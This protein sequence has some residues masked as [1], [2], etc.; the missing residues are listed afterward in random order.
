M[1]DSFTDIKTMINAHLYT[2]TVQTVDYN[3]NKSNGVS[4]RLDGA[5]VLP[6]PEPEQKPEPNPDFSAYKNQTKWFYGI[7]GPMPDDEVWVKPGPNRA[8]E[9]VWK[10]EYGWYDVNKTHLVDKE[11][12]NTIIANDNELCWAATSSNILHWWLRMNEKYVK[13]YDE[14]NPE[15]AKQRPS[16]EYPLKGTAYGSKYQESEIFQYYIDHF[17]DEAG[18]GNAGVNWFISGYKVT[19]PEMIKPGKAGFFDDVFP[20]GKYVATYAQGL[21]KQRFTQIIIDVIEN[22]K[23]LGVA[24]QAGSSHLMTIWGAEFD[25]EG[26]VKAVYIADNNVEQTTAP[27]YKDLTRRLLRYSTIPGTTATK[28]EIS[29]FGTDSYSAAVSLII[30]DLGVKQR[31]EYFK[32]KGI[33]IE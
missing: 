17:K 1:A 9:L 6:E 25:E 21:S 20:Q 27:Y 2:F 7:S 23:A 10:K 4:T 3:G 19:A 31:E 29:A 14:I 22:H 11:N 32:K 30:V 13:K 16:N 15:K 26:Y 12:K 33:V 5:P 8:W 28:T 18:W 24:R